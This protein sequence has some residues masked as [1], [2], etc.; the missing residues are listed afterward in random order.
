MCYP[1]TQINVACTLVSP[2][3]WSMQIPVSNKTE[4]SESKL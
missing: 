1:I 2:Y 3:K 4:A